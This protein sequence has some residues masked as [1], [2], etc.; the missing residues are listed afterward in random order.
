[1]PKSFAEKLAGYKQYDPKKEG[2][3]SVDEWRAAWDEV[4]G[5]E[6]AM[7]FLGVESPLTIM[8]F[9]EMPD[10][11]TLKKRYRELMLKNHPDKNPGDP[12]ATLMTQKIVAAYSEL[13]RKL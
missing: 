8:G 4:M 7:G 3:G 9:D 1:M 13:T 11:A 5:H 12:G 2:Y 10:A 6:E